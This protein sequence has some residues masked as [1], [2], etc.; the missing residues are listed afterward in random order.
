MYEQAK[1]KLLR[2]YIC[3]KEGASTD[4]SS[5]EKGLLEDEED[6]CHSGDAITD[7]QALSNSSDSDGGTQRRA[8]LETETAQSPGPARP[9]QSTPTDITSRNVD[10]DNTGV[11]SAHRSPR[12]KRPTHLCGIPTTMV[13]WL[14]ILTMLREMMS[15]RLL[16]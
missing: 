12:L 1:L 6:G 15:Y 11:S 14:Y 3:T 16:R 5:E 7:L 8:V 2:F 9:S 4:H 10:K 13:W